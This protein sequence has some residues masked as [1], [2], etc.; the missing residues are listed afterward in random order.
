M[1]HILKEEKT[2]WK[3]QWDTRNPWHYLQPWRSKSCGIQ[4]RAILSES[5]RE[6]SHTTMVSVLIKSTLGGITLKLMRNFIC[7]CHSFKLNQFNPEFISPTRS[8]FWT[9]NSY[10][11][12]HNFLPRRALSAA[13]PLV[14]NTAPTL[15]LL[16][17]KTLVS[18]LTPLLHT[19][20]PL[21][22]EILL[23]PSSKYIQKVLEWA[24]T[25]MHGAGWSGLWSRS[26][27]F[28]ELILKYNQ[29]IAPLVSMG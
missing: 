9:S 7:I 6:S 11:H 13:F 24:G 8:V 10:I 21:L 28:K 20:H 17:S 23:T 12:L 16:N 22:E 14:V 29:G 5:F 25:H 18:S 3:Q 4:K 2:D 15:L 26:V 1:L 19:P 27:H